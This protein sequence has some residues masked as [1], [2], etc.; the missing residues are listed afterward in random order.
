MSGK[1]CMRGRADAILHCS[2]SGMAV[3]MT[4][5]SSWMLARHIVQA[6][7]CATCNAVHMHLVLTK[8]S[9]VDVSQQLLHCWL[10]QNCW[11]PGAKGFPHLSMLLM[12]VQDWYQQLVDWPPGACMLLLVVWLVLLMLLGLTGC[13]W[14]AIVLL[15]GIRCTWVLSVLPVLLY[16]LGMQL[17]ACS[18]VAQTP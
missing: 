17:Q 3:G 1:L 15:W 2:L 18:H 10:C 11:M 12:H 14:L 13:A 5:S 9:H 4:Q 8:N 16:G 7:G 6:T